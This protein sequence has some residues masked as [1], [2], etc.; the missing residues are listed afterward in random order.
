MINYQALR[1]VGRFI[2]RNAPIILTGLGVVGVVGTTTLAVKESKKENPNY[3]LTV[4]AGALTVGCIIGGSVTQAM[5]TKEIADAFNNLA[6]RMGNYKTAVDELGAA[7][8]INSVS[9]MEVDNPDEMEHI[10]EDSVTGNG[11]YEEKLHWFWDEYSNTWF[12]GTWKQVYYANM[13][14][15]EEFSKVGF[16]PISIYYNCLE[17]PFADECPD[18]LGFDFENLNINWEV[19]FIPFDYDDVTAP[20]GDPG[21]AITWPIEPE[22][23][24]SYDYL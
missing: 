11:R 1:K 24:E 14:L 9:K 21:F 23:Y 4:I 13:V 12:V 6:H 19:G 16:A 22:I 17:L 15:Q 7:A 3:T 5:K 2:E 18:E 20:N 8:I 10:T